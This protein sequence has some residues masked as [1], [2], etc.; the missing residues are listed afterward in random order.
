MSEQK[1]MKSPADSVSATQEE[2]WW[3]TVKVIVQA[4]LIALVVRTVAVPAVQHPLGIADPDAADRRLSVRLEIFLRLLA[5]FAAEL[6]R[7]GAQRLAGAAVLFAAQAR[8][9]R[10]V[11]AARRAA[12]GFHQASDRPARR[13]G[14]DDK[15]PALYQRHRHAAR[16]GARDF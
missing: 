3:E 4:L 11:P 10:R 5:L 6:P 13:Q 15:G 12:A 2:G 7:S 1:F 14:A 8:R 9:Y 16:T